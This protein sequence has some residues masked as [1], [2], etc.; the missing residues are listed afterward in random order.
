MRNAALTII[1]TLSSVAT[2]AQNF[3]AG[4]KIFKMNCAAC[5]KMDAKLI[6]PSLMNVVSEQGEEWT[7]KWIYNNEELRKSGDAHAIAIYEEYNK[8]VMPNYSYLTDQELS[9]LVAYMK[10]WKEVQVAKTVATAAAPAAAT[11]TVDAPQPVSEEWSSTAK[12]VVGIAAAALILT[13]VTMYTLI[14][15]FKAIVG[16]RLYDA[17]EK[18]NTHEKTEG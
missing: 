16:Y 9:D 8:Q 15:A 6:G 14:Q 7:R 11:G 12:L 10:D 5:H 1:M 18:G 3:E 4:E 17:P 13:I 2:I